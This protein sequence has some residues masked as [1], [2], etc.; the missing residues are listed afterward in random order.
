ML[1]PR[2]APGHLVPMSS[3]ASDRSCAGPGHCAGS[4]ICTAKII[5]CIPIMTSTLRPLVRAS[6]SSIST[7]APDLDSVDD[8]REIGAS[9]CGEPAQDGRFIYM[10]APNGDQ[11][12]NTSNRYPTIRRSEASDARTPS[13][14][15][16]W[17]RT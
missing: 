4:Y 16:A 17:L 2:P 9:A 11:T 1:P 7:S 8:Y 5:Q 10:V 6:G 13:G 3:S 14:G 15:L 12:S